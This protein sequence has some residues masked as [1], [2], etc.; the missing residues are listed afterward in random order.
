MQRRESDHGPAKRLVHTKKRKARRA[1]A[2]ATA[3]NPKQLLNQR[4]RERDEALEQ[5]A[6]TS[7]ILTVISRSPANVQPVLDTIVR[8]AAKLCNSH[9][10][11]VLLR[12]S[13]RLRI[14]AHH[15]PI[16]IDFTHGPINRDW[17]SGRCVLDRVPVHVHDLAA[18][19]EEFPLGRDISVRLKQ[20][21]VL[22]VP[23]LRDGEAI[24]SLTMRRREVSPFS[25]KQIALL[26]AFSAQAVIAIENTRL[27]EAEQQRESLE[28]QTPRPQRF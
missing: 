6:A 9:D 16:K 11:V 27:F 13:D 17:V 25:E 14:A 22:A 8:A 26:R 2:P 5:Q 15:G 1:R 21:T 19:G 7:E 12:D 20:H 3:T 28:Q 23:F 4:T 10:A 24:G 18:E